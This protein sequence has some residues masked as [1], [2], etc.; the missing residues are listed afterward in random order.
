MLVLT[1]AIEIWLK[2]WRPWHNIQFDIPKKYS[3]HCNVSVATEYFYKIQNNCNSKD[4]KHF[5]FNVSTRLQS[6]SFL[7]MTATVKKSNLGYL[8]RGHVN[9][10]VAMELSFCFLAGLPV[11]LFFCFFEENRNQLMQCLLISKLYIYMWL[12]RWP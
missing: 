5:Y 1:I 11:W 2:R 9:A 10:C 6:S 4:W 7:M 12:Y 8:L 3:C